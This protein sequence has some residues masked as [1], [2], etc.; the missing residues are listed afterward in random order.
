MNDDEVEAV[1]D[2]HYAGEAQ[3]LASA[4]RRTC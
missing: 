3:T 2:D 1:L 4:P